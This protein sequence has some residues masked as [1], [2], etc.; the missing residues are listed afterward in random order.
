MFSF[1]SLAEGA[2][3]LGVFWEELLMF[4]LV[5]VSFSIGVAKRV[6]GGYEKACGVL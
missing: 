1:G 5:Q 4:F 6:V 3:T 2:S